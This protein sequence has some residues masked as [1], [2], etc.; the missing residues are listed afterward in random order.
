[1]AV[2]RVPV[3]WSPRH[4]QLPLWNYLENGGRR[5][6][7]V[8]HRRA[9]K[10]ATALNWTVV[11]AM[12]RPGLYWHLLPT[13]A[14]GKKIVWDGITR[15]G[16]KFLSA[17]PEAAVK[18]FNNVEMK[19]ELTN[20]SIW[21][22][23]G[24]L[25][26]GTLVETE[27]GSIPIEEI[28]VGEMVLT[29]NGYRKVLASG[30]SGI[31]DTLTKI[32]YGDTSITGTVNH[33]FF[34]ERGKLE[35]K[36]IRRLDRLCTLKNSKGKSITKIT[37]GTIRTTS[38]GEGK[39][40]PCTWLYGKL[41][42]E[43]FHRTVVSTTR[44][45]TKVITD[46]RIL[47][48]SRLW[49]II[50]SLTKKTPTLAA[51]STK[52]NGKKLEKLCGMLCHSLKRLA[53][54]AERHI[55]AGLR[56]DGIVTD[57]K[58]L[59]TGLGI[60]VY[61]LTVEGERCFYANTVLVSNTDNVDRLVGSNPVGCVFSEYSLQDPRAWDYIRPIL[62]E[63][64][65]WAVFIYTPRGRNHGYEL[66]EMAKGNPRWFCQ[67]LHISD[68]KAIGDEAIQEERE[69]GMPEE[70]IQQEFFCSFDASMVG[71][72]YSRQMDKM[73]HENRICK[74]PV[75]PRLPVHT[76]WDLGVGDSTSIV[77]Y[78]QISQEIRIIDYYESSGE[79][80]AHYAKVLVEKGYLYGE[81]F[82]PWDIEV[83]ELSMGKSRKDVAAMLG[84]KFRTQKRVP[85]DEGI[86]AVRNILDRVWIDEAR[87]L[88]LIKALRN[89]KKKWDDKH[90][91]YATHP[92]HDWSSHA[93]DA[94]RYMALSIK[95]RRQQKIKQYSTL[96][97]ETNYDP[98][99]APNGTNQG[100]W[101]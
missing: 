74:I 82:A 100:W 71:S 84:I 94:M 66:Y 72:Y 36:D 87:C 97:A 80:L 73:L 88:P 48:A 101:E 57:V 21:Q 35:A 6:V 1:M 47:S 75:D 15:D 68:T 38:N 91:C 98:L 26:A 46:L 86:E 12:K 27:R 24:C 17:W 92:E 81:H 60:P 8:W 45:M 3:D 56:E 31:V 32:T 83:Q 9:G 43:K 33:P 61:N 99:Y 10:D 63:N 16:R 69:A 44:T 89:Y 58:T 34:T 5:A 19:L 22:V 78:Q 85:V 42:T 70:M 65:G 37:E 40:D 28:S 77:F 18:T 59:D 93:C 90:R 20:G 23:V 11:A 2:V 13:Y 52:S 29:P 67:M 14:Q 53:S 49:S 76:A 62:A 7:A 64:G 30:V 54:T 51:K 96:E 55:S 79:G 39:S 50:G 25:V 41:L 4:Y 95:D